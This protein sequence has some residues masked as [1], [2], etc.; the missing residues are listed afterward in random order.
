LISA[1]ALRLVQRS[2]GCRQQRADAAGT[3][4]GISRPRGCGT[5][6]DGHDAGIGTGFMRYGKVQNEFA[7]AFRKAHGA[8]WIRIRHQEQERLPAISGRKV[9]RPP[10]SRFELRGNGA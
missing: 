2:I 7:N 8:V 5:D 6:A 9:A 3:V 1:A 10:S 4:P